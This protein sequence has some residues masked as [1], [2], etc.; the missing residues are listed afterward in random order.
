MAGIECD[1]PGCTLLIVGRCADCKRSYCPRHWNWGVCDRC[2]SATK[3]TAKK[4]FLIGLV[5][6]VFGLAVGM[7]AA[8]VNISLFAVIGV[9]SG[10][11][12]TAMIIGAA[13]KGMY[14]G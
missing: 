14:S 2:S 8:S 13:I 7:P 12:G 11:V 9:V 5:L 3:Q 6:F 10:L 1:Y 4:R